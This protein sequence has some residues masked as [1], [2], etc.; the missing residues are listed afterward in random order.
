MP[1]GPRRLS[2][3]RGARERQHGDDSCSSRQLG[4]TRATHRTPKL[5]RWIEWKRG[6]PIRW[7][8]ADGPVLTAQSCAFS[9][10]GAVLVST[11]R[12]FKLTHPIRLV[13]LA[14]KVVRFY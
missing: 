9:M 4:R 5:S 10:A 8:R 7:G 6:A 1:L 2:D 13:S 3:Y 12:S 11:R 14:F